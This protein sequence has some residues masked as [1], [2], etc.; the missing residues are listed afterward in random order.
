VRAIDLDAHEAG[1]S[2]L[3]DVLMEQPGGAD[4]AWRGGRRFVQRLVAHAGPSAK[5]ADLPLQRLEV[6]RPGTLDG[7]EIRPLQ[8]RPLRPTD[9]RVRVAVTGLNFRDVLVALGVYPGTGIPLG[10]ECAGTVIEAGDAVTKLRVGDAVF[11]FAHDSMGSEVVVAEAFMARAPA[12]L[13]TEQA[14]ALP[15][16]FLTAHHGLHGIAGLQRGQRVLI[17]AAAGGSGWLRCSWRCARGPRSLPPPA[18][19]R[20]ASTCWPWASRM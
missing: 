6:V 19:T 1:A 12:G 15:V 4:F 10:A 11:G 8:A 20:S 3:V 2:A 17:H 5:P 7:L 16:A 9:V 18:R 13:S 14:A